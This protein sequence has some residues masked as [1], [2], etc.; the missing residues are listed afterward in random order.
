M[1]TSMQVPVQISFRD[2][3]V[4]DAVEAACWAEAEKL[5]R[6]YDRITA[7][8]IVVSETNGDGP[9]GNTFQVRIDLAVPNGDI[10]VNREPPTRHGDD[11]RVAVREAF[12]R[13]RRQLDDHVRRHRVTGRT[14]RT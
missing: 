6:V 9:R 13:A 1:E 12:A 7:C 4:S 11:V 10:L 3:P 5:E 2:M 14:H 8:R